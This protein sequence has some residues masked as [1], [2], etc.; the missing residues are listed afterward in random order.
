MLL[1]LA[2]MLAGG[3]STPGIPQGSDPAGRAR[4]AQFSSVEEKKVPRM[5]VMN[6]PDNWPEISELRDRQAAHP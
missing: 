2:M 1:V 4:A 6:Y 3:C 5:G